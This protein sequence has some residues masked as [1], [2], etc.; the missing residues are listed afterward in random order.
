M[1]MLTV[2]CVCKRTKRQGAWILEYSEPVGKPVSH[3]YCPDCFDDL[4][5]KFPEISP[6]WRKETAVTTESFSVLTGTVVQ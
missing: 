3:G 2:C 1:I 5:E 4:M 6:D